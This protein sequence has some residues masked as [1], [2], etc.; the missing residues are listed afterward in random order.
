MLTTEITFDDGYTSC[1]AIWLDGKPIG[2]IWMTGEGS[3]LEFQAISVSGRMAMFS[4]REIAR[5][6]IFAESICGVNAAGWK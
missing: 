1:E 4:F 3:T 2:C 5:L 6:W